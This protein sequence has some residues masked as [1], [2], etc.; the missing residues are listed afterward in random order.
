[1]KN[2]L[3]EK[4]SRNSQFGPHKA[5]DKAY[6]ITFLYRHHGYPIRVGWTPKADIHY[7]PNM[8]D[9][10]SNDSAEIVLLSLWAHFTASSLDYYRHRWEL[11]KNAIARF[12]AAW[13]KRY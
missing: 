7:V 10:L 11:I 6:N 9:E 8:I 1:M 2:T 4:K 5:V 13:D 12:T 3:I